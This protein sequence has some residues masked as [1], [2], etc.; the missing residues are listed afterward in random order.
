MQT[1]KHRF[2]NPAKIAD[3]PKQLSPVQMIAKYKSS[4]QEQI[5][6]EKKLQVQCDS[7]EVKQE[8][9]QEVT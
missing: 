9:K 1:L 5:F 2:L 3:P 7:K 6:K 4:L 8:V